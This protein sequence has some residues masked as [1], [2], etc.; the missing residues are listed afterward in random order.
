MEH[1]GK[2]EGQD[3]ERWGIQWSLKQELLQGSQVSSARCAGACVA[4]ALVAVLMMSQQ[5]H[6]SALLSSVST[7]SSEDG[8]D[9]GDVVAAVW[10]KQSLVRRWSI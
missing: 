7:V 9:G 10:G 4:E 5:C 8:G 1:K 6:Q 3:K 2:S